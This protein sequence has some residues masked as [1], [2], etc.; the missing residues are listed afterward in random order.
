MIYD[1]ILRDRDFFERKLYQKHAELERARVTNEM[2][3]KVESRKSEVEEVTLELEKYLFDLK[4]LRAVL[5]T[6]D[7]DFKNRRLDYVDSLITDS[8]S[9]IFP[10]DGLKAKLHCEFNRKNGV[11]LEL[12]DKYDNE[13]SPDICSGKL[14]Q[15]LIS[16]AAVAG[17]ANGLGI[18]QLYVD[19]AFG[20]AAPSILGEIGKVI[21]KS[22]DNGMQIILIAQNSGLYQDLPRREIKL[23]KSVETDAIEV[24]SE[25]D[26]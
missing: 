2:R 26:F 10:D 12:V 11:D 21:Q 4:R 17:I 5:E 16:F 22:V 23:K 3:E 20:V 13:L 14:Q 24:V 18:K 6:E 19:E 25:E 7:R 1:D 8:L 15:Y 9:A